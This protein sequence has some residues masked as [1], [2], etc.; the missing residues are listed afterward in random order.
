MGRY[1]SGIIL[2]Y[3]VMICSG[4]DDDISSLL[5]HIG[6]TDSEENQKKLFVKASLSPWNN[7]IFSD[8]NTWTFRIEQDEDRLPMWYKKNRQGRE[9]SFRQAVCQWL[10]EHSFI[11][12]NIGLLSK[13]YYSLKDCTVEEISGNASVRLSHSNIRNVSGKAKILC[14]SDDSIVK[15]ISENSIVEEMSGYSTIG[16]MKGYSTVVDMR[17][18]SIIEQMN[19]HSTVRVMWH[20]SF[21][22]KMTNHSRVRFMMQQSKIGTMKGM[23]AVEVMKDNAQIYKM[24]EE[25]Y[26]EA[27]YDNSRIGMPK[28]DVSSM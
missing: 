15:T 21:V 2:R 20:E 7:D 10:N 3:R 16:L 27:S 13:G 19:D 11:G 26:L 28:E 23:S 6:I 9:K 22:L 14:M 1:K 18:L 25:S 5:K 8:P 17:D 12:Q 4:G 24:E